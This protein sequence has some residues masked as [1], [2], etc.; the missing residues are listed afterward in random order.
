M[1][2]GGLWCS[3]PYIDSS[4]IWEAATDYFRQRKWTVV[5]R[6]GRVHK[7][8]TMSKAYQVVFLFLWS[9]LV[10]YVCRWYHI[11][12][13]AANTYDG[14]SWTVARGFTLDGFLGNILRTTVACCA[15]CLFFIGGLWCSCSSR[16]YLSRECWHLRLHKLN[17]DH[18]VIFFG[19]EDWV[20]WYIFLWW[21]MMF[22]FV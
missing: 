4:S 18:W 21:V 7:L 10:L 2:W 22:V 3:Y 14:E 8:N 16:Q 11:W 6:H 5:Y 15:C 12:E 13:A 19:T 1:L 20:S 9:V 17:R